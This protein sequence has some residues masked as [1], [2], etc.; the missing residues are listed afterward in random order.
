MRPLVERAD[1]IVFV[2]ARTNQNGT[3]SWTLFPETARYVHIDIDGQEVGRN[4]EALRLV[5]DAKL[6]L[7]ALAEA[8][9]KHGPESRDRAELER[10]IGRARA[11]HEEEV[12]GYVGSDAVPIRPE[13]VMRELDALLTPESL[14]VCDASYSAIWAANYL[15]SRRA[16]QRFLNGR[17][18]AG[19]GWG[20]PAAL[21]AKVAHPHR[22]VFCI[23]GD[24]AFAHVWS[25]LETAKRLGIKVTLIVLSNQILGYQ[26]HAEDV[27]YGDHT[28]ACQLGPVDHAAIARACGCEGIRVEDPSALAPAL[29]RATE[30]DVTTLIDVVIDP[31]AYPPITLYEG[32]IAV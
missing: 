25:E 10:T 16:G 5:G 19:L 7:V 4:Y 24:G 23:A 27:L 26:W 30:S 18:L 28:D 13:R 12:A 6:T 31:R 2:G 20:L 11:A 17:G 1:V 22:D 3:D 8:L 9:A 15:R 32:K 14:I 21:G 29:R